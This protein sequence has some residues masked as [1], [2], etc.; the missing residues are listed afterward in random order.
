MYCADR[1]DIPDIIRERARQHRTELAEGKVR[2]YKKFK[3]DGRN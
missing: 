1:L 2:I 3:I